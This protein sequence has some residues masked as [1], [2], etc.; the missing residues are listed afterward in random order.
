VE[1]RHRHERDR[2][3]VEAP[4]V[5]DREQRGE[6]LVG[7]HDALGQPGSARGVE[8][9]HAVGVLGVVRRVE[10]LVGGGEPALVVLAD[11]EHATYG[12]QRLHPCA[13]VREVGPEHDQRRRGVLDD[14]DQLVVGEPVV[15]RRGPGPDARGAEEQ[16]EELRP[17]LAQPHHARAGPHAVGGH[18]PVE[19]GVGGVLSVE[20]HRH[21]IRGAHVPA[22][23]V[24]QAERHE[25]PPRKPGTRA[26]VTPTTGTRDRNRSYGTAEES[27]LTVTGRCDHADGSSTVTD[28]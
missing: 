27:G 24:G 26:A 17:V 16:V 10:H 23:D 4:V 14:D 6:L 13:Q 25:E 22:H 19:L 5:A 28:P 1:Q 11:D 9:Q 15:Q 2:L 7:E 21:Q 8:L 20:R 12:V 3:G 18:R